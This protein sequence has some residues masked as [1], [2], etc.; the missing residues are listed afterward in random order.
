M[1]SRFKYGH[2]GHSHDHDGQHDDRP[3]GRDR[4]EFGFGRHGGPPHRGGPR[5]ARRGDIRLALLGGLTEGSAHGYELIQR[6]SAR[7]GG[8]WKPSPGSVYPTLQMLEDAGFVSASQLDDKKVYSI[9]E[10]GQAE[11]QAKTAE[12][13]GPPSWLDPEAAGSHDELR[14]AVAQL[15]MAAKQV[16]M[17]DNDTHIDTAAGVIN[18]ARR[19]LYQLLA[20]A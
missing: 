3:T 13:G 18:E 20:E 8:R 7:T 5:R 14:K 17:S 4:G 11:L 9:T 15:V 19:K 12:A 16:G 1:R 10:A 2:P 6:L